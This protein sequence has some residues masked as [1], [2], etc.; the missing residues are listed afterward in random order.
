M[1]IVVSRNIWGS[2]LPLDL[3]RSILKVKEDSRPLIN[4]LKDLIAARQARLG[5]SG[6]SIN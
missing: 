2:P 6:K 1:A 4:S 3:S 5:C